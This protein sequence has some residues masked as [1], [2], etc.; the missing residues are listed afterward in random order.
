MNYDLKGIINVKEGSITEILN[1]YVGEPFS[2]DVFVE[3]QKKIQAVDGVAYFEASVTPMNNSSYIKLNLVIHEQAMIYK[4]NYTGNSRVRSSDIT[5]SLS[6][7]AIGKFVD[8]SLMSFRLR[9]VNEVEKAYEG[10]G[11]DFVNVS[12]SWEIEEDTNRVTLDFTI[13]EGTQTRVSGIIFVGNDHMSE[14][15]LRKAMSQKVRSLF[16]NG[17]YDPA[18]ID[19]D[20]TAIKNA[21]ATQGYIDARVLSVE[22]AE[23]ESSSDKFREVTLTYFIDEGEQWLY[24]GMTVKGN[25]VYST[26]RLSEEMT[27][28][29]GTIINM[30]QITAQI[31]RITDV[32][33]N[34][35][36]IACSYNLTEKRDAVKH[37][38]EYI[39][40]LREG[41]QSH[42][43][44]ILITGL[45]KTEEYVMLREVTLKEGQVFSKAD[46]I[47]SA[48][49]I[50][51]TGLLT[52]I[53]Y[54][55]YF[56]SEE[57]GVVVEFK[58][59][60]GNQMDV[61][62]GAT[63]G[64]NVDGFPV[65]GF[66]SWANHNFMRKAKD[67]S[68]ST[69]LSPDAQTVSLSFGDKWFRGVRWSNSVSLNFSHRKYEGELQKSP[70]S[71]YYDGRNSEKVYPLGMDSYS[72]WKASDGEYPSSQYLMDYDQISVGLGYNSGYTFIW[73][74]GRLSLN[75]GISFSINRAYYDEKKF[76]P[77]EKLT[78]RYH[79][80]WQWSNRLTFGVSWDGR[81][82]I[83]EPTKGY[84]LN[85]GYTYAGGFLGGISNYM[86]FST[87][88]S[89]FIKVLTVGKPEN[90]RNLMFE[91]ASNVSVM[92]PQYYKNNDDTENRGWGF[93]D[94]H[95]GA[96]KYEMLYIDGMTIARGHDII[97]DQ[98]F[99][100]DNMAQ[101]SLP[102]VRNVLNAE[103]FGSAT[104][105]VKE[106]DD[107]KSGLNWYF[108]TGF[109]VK[110][111][112]SGF[113]LGFYLVKTA[114]QLS[115]GTFSWGKGS[116]FNSSNKSGQGL[117]FV[118]AISTTLT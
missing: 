103:V 52:D 8:P 35:G 64:G 77:F 6:T 112:V 116:I 26:A 40:E 2:D 86:K 56:G 111:K 89:Y 73:N 15:T 24:G 114:S 106:Y 96:T 25:T 37:Q 63:F 32:Y 80:D 10:K 72:H 83:Q 67:I 5:E 12:V 84:V 105:I 53:N 50:Y 48:Q 38:V 82:F 110:L 78:Y 17:F 22:T 45:T 33:Y 18:K 117:K 21:Y 81:D 87:G 59:Q 88:G 42:V 36:Y 60:E 100:W 20:K 102:L 57:N 71:D 65:S 61:Q 14:G 58:V 31:L 76:N 109:G 68:V 62:F 39:V 11:F 43:E 46:L 7:I 23:V 97:Y 92:L 75:G 90:K 95:L 47:T 41:A 91:V 99:L 55:I 94:P 19:N 98:V 104:A 74:P 49:N 107:F 54:D 115:G 44:K 113:P 13:E 85:T 51:N 101:F 9:A 69:N 66:L 4:I 34:S 79:E 1:N 27:I 28:K 3:I 93:H 30:D 16:M 70:E 29:S 108:S 118:L